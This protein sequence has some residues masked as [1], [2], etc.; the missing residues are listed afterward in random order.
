VGPVLE[1][2]LIRLADSVEIAQCQA[3]FHFPAMGSAFESIQP[4]GGSGTLKAA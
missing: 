1:V 4:C 3:S 2:P